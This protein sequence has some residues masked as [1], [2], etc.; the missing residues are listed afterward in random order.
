[1]T[2]Y[3]LRSRSKTEPRALDYHN[4]VKPFTKA[5]LAKIRKTSNIEAYA[6]ISYTPQG[7]KVENLQE[8]DK[9][10]CENPLYGD[11]LETS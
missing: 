10:S 1:M 2:I 3:T 11:N 4:D 6:K 7:R 9:S 8:G 5:Y